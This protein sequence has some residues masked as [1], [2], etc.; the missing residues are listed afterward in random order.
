[1]SPFHKE[2]VKAGLLISWCALS[3]YL[4]TPDPRH[5]G[6]FIPAMLSKIFSTIALSLY[7]IL[8]SADTLRDLVALKYKIT[9]VTYSEHYTYYEAKYLTSLWLCIPYWAYVAY[10][11]EDFE[12]QN[13]FGAKRD[14][15]FR[16]GVYYGTAENATTAIEQHKLSI[17]RH[18]KEFFT[19]REKPKRVATYQ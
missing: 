18:R 19:V 13:M 10:E 8:L 16:S 2:L 9:K 11:Y 12:A 3:W 4:E 17:K 1:M 14:V 6:L 5:T 7:T 15:S